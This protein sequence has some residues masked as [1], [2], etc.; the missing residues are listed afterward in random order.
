[1][2]HM[3]F[4]LGVIEEFNAI[5]IWRAPSDNALYIRR[6]KIVP[7]HCKIQRERTKTTPMEKKS[8][9]LLGQ[10][11]ALFETWKLGELKPGIDVMLIVIKCIL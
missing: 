3:C 10:N 1:M 2:F 11:K 8:R 9:A 6:D 5:Y 4:D 7:W